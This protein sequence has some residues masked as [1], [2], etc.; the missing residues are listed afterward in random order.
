[1]PANCAHPAHE[2]KLRVMAG[3]KTGVQVTLM[4]FKTL[5]FG[6]ILLRRFFEES[7]KYTLNPF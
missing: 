6:K 7:S 5:M 2:K 4:V 1:M 3:T